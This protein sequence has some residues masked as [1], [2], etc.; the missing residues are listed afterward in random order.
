MRELSKSHREKLAKAAAV[1]A[2]K[3]KNKKQQDVPFI[4]NQASQLR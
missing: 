1:H 4:M 3:K 2:E